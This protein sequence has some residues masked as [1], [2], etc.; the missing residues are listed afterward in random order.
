MQCAPQ[1]KSFQS[2][3]FLNKLQAKFPAQAQTINMMMLAGQDNYFSDLVS[4]LTPSFGW[5]NINKHEC[6]KAG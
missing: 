6:D 1:E 4:V 3:E 5:T 2:Y